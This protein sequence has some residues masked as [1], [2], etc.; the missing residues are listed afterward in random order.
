MS[1]IIIGN[2][3]FHILFPD[4]LRKLTSEEL[5]GLK[6]SIEQHGVVDAVIVDEA[7]GVMDGQHRLKIASEL[8]LDF[9]PF[10][11]HAGL[12]DASKQELAVALNIER[13]QL[14]QDEQQVERQK[15]IDRV[16]ESR[17]EGK[18]LRTIADEEGVSHPQI[19]AD[20]REATGKGLPV[21]PETGR[22]QGRDGKSRP[23]RKGTGKGR[24]D[25][26]VRR[27]KRAQDRRAELDR[28]AECSRPANQPMWNII[29]GDSVELLAI[30]APE[31][32]RLIFADPPYNVGV[33]YGEGSNADLLPDEEYVVWFG[34]WI[35][36]AYRILTC[37]GSLWVLINDEYVAEYAVA[38]K[39]VGFTIRNWIKWYETFG[40]NCTSKFNRTSRHILYAVKDSKHFV[41]NRGAVSRLSD[42]QTKYNDQRANREGKILDDVWTDIPRLAGT[43]AER[44]P[45]FPTQLPVALLRRIVCCASEPGDLILDPFCGSGTTG[46]AALAAGRCFHGFEKSEKFAQLA[47]K[48]LQ[49]VQLEVF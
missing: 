14:T 24:S 40:V 26:S 3:T 2:Q 30:Q 35:S 49:S 28:A 10:Q 19:I 48:R 11:I 7:F 17:R 44:I 4:L 43:H 20:L 46:A 22:V 13:R 38:I 21:E 36:E 31:A 18:S 37:D 15:R 6:A 8:G 34:K 32:N 12:D 23:A 33:D 9:V 42:R 39:A 16:A 27:K 47:R 5:T 1:K 29:Q 25:A 45:D 41:F